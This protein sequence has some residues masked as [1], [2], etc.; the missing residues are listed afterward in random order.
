MLL[1]RRDTA[2]PW[3]A[4]RTAERLYLSE[5][6]AQGLLAELH[7]SGIIECIDQQLLLYQY[8][9]NSDE[10]ARMID[11]LAD[12]YTGNLINVTNLIHSRTGKKAQQFANA[13]KWRKDS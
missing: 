2:Q 6:V 5:K 9:P 12:I 1:L 11:R 8:R 7:S 10:V 4:G 3:D 13:F